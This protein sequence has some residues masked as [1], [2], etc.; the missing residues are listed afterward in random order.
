MKR[1]IGPALRLFGIL[2]VI[3]GVIYPVAVTAVARIFLAQPAGG[4][5]IEREG[6]VVGSALVAQPFTEDRYFWPRPSASGHAT[7]A[8]GAS[9]LG[10]ASGKLQAQVA[11][12]VQALRA[13]HGGA[14]SVPVPAELV[15]TS[16]SGLDPHLSRE[17]VL[18][19]MPRVARARGRSEAELLLL[20]DRVLEPASGGWLGASRVNVLRL[21]LALDGAE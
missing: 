1:I 5:L 15:T 12:R 2:T 8:S 20:I 18:F 6:R 17:A 7:V 10:P 9:N 11:G 16:A 13:A 19:Q 14:D 4:S 3:T 21:N